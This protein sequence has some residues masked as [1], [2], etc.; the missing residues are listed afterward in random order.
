MLALSVTALAATTSDGTS[1]RSLVV[2]GEVTDPFSLPWTLSLLVGGQQMC[3]ATLV[4]PRWAVTA[5]HCIGGSQVVPSAFSVGVYR[6]NLA[7][8]NEHACSEVIEAKSIHRHPSYNP[9]TIANDIG[10]IELSRSAACAD[11]TNPN[12]DPMMLALIDGLS[13]PTV[14]VEGPNADATYLGVDAIVSGW[15]STTP[16]LPVYPVQMHSATLPVVKD[17]TC[18]ALVGTDERIEV[19]AGPLEGGVDACS[20]DSGGPLAVV[21]SAAT[22][23]GVVS[24]GVTYAC[25]MTMAPGIYARVSA[26]VD[27]MLSV[28]PE[29]DPNADPGP[30]SP[31]SPPP[32]YAEGL[33]ELL[34]ALLAAEDKAA[35]QA[36]LQAY[37]EAA[38][39]AL[40]EHV[41]SVLAPIADWSFE[42]SAAADYISDT[43]DY[44]GDFLHE[45]E[46]MWP[47]LVE[48]YDSVMAELSSVFSW[49]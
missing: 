26:F 8:P 10:L 44:L 27:W 21:G 6:H 42:D 31:P 15:G 19:C 45:Y 23:V 48:L 32:L 16:A 34:A 20:G 25:A 46:D 17:E 28:A 38:V 41:A 18:K 13:S 4:H 22:L 35:R 3:G 7:T 39:V 12:Y 36:I 43:L 47:E 11:A 9:G 2:G 49:L 1:H 29:L 5:A 14:L 30:P 24:Y 33:E 37:V 40:Q